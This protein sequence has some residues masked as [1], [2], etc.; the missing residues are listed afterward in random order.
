MSVQKFLLP[1]L[2]A[3]SGWAL[4]LTGRILFDPD[5]AAAVCYIVGSFTA[6]I[7]VGMVLQSVRSR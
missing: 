6:G 3:V 7:S 5:P 4:V 1:F 2:V